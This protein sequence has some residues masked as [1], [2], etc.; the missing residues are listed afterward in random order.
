[1]I[2]RNSIYG[3]FVAILLGFV[4]SYANA[5]L[6]SIPVVYVD[7]YITVRSS[8][9]FAE[10]KSFHL[11]DV[12]SLAVFLEFDPN[13]VSISNLDETLLLESWRESLWVSYRG[14]PQVISSKNEKDLTRLEA[15]YDFQITGCP[16]PDTQCPGG[17]AY[18]LS[19]ITLGTNLM[20]DSGR[21]VSTT[22]IS[23][24]PSPSF[25]GLP[26]A[27]MLNNG[28]LESFNLYFPSRAFGLPI[29][30]N[31]NPN[32]SLI[33]LIIGLILVST[34]VVVP[35]ARSWLRH[36]VTTQIGILGNRWERV[37]DRLQGEKL[38]DEEFTEGV[39]VAITWYCY[40]EYRVN[41]V[42]WSEAENKIS[43]SALFPLKSIYLQVTQGTKLDIQQRVDML[44]QLTEI[45][46]G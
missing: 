43:E 33:L 35:T 4:S 42:Y 28:R 12:L 7:K 20:D 13:R 16:N 6:F 18:P 40:D 46:K 44:K 15:F 1:M 11:G 21:V 24:R 8:V 26:S 2:I 14:P 31:V 34:M 10:E 32:H 37:L 29:S 5:K 41:P 3:I 17:K 19:E 23:F 22:D 36:R 39:R 9:L 30:A 45:F 25:V 38:D 27:L